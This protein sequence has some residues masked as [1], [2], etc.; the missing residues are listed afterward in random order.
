MS[1]FGSG[2]CL[3]GILTLIVISPLFSL[4]SPKMKI[5]CYFIPSK[6][7]LQ[8]EWRLFIVTAHVLPQS[9]TANVLLW[10]QHFTEWEQICGKWHLLFY[11]AVREDSSA[12]NISPESHC[13]KDNVLC[14]ELYF[15]VT[16]LSVRMW[17]FLRI[18]SGKLIKGRTLTLWDNLPHL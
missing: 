15:V 3:L 5:Q 11:T 2:V 18:F 10:S 8:R 12:D 7:A 1:C 6:R 13:H 14:E 9:C 16:T 17:C 4:H